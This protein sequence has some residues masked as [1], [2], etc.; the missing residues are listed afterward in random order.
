MTGHYE[1]RPDETLVL[2]GRLMD[3]D[4]G[5]HGYFL[6]DD[7]GHEFALPDYHDDRSLVHLIG[8]HVAVTGWPEYDESGLINALREAQIE[9]APDPFS[10]TKIPAAVDIEL[11]MARAPGP[12]QGG[13]A[14]LTDDEI[15]DFYEGLR[16]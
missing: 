12:I 10:G 1:S 7:V 15:E 11:I 16:G 5:R 8:R 3:L 13:I 14:D 6:R 9:S 2:V 4:Y